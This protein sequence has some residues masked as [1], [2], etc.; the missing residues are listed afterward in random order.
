MPQ[1]KEFR[2]YLRTYNGVDWLYWFY[3]PITATVDNTTAVTE[4][5]R[6]P[7]GWQEYEIIFERGFTY[8]G[9]FTSFTTPL[10]FLKDGA[11]ILRHI[12]YTYGI[13]YKIELLVEQ[14]DHSDWTY[15]T[16]F[17][18]DIDMSKTQDEF[19]YLV[20]PIIEGGFVEKLKS[21]AETPYTYELWNNTDKKWIEHDGIEMEAK[22]SWS[23]GSTTGVEMPSNGFDE[24][25]LWG[26]YDTEGTNFDQVF[27]DVSLTPSVQR[28]VLRNNS[29]SSI[30]YLIKIRGTYVIS[31]NVSF[32]GNGYLTIR[33]I[34]YDTNG[35]F[36]AVHDLWITAS[37]IVG[38]GVST[39]NTYAV[40][41]SETVTIATGNQIA[42]THILSDSAGSA[43][44]AFTNGSWATTSV[45][46]DLDIIFNNRYETTYVPAL[47]AS[48]VF[49]LL[50][51]SISE[52]A[53]TVTSTLLTTTLNNEHY[54]SSGDGIRGLVNATFTTTFADFYKWVNSKFG[55][56][57]Y[58][59]RAAN[60]VYLEAK[61]V[62]FNKTMN[63]SYTITSVDDF[64][65]IPFTE[66]AFTNLSIGSRNF[67]YDAKGVDSNE[68]TNGRDEW[69]LTSKY[70]TT[71]TR[72]SGA[73]KEYVSPY[74][75]DVHGIEQVRANLSGK[76][77]ADASSDGEIFVLHCE[78]SSSGSYTPPFFPS[79]TEDLH[80]LFR[81]ALN[82]TAGASYWQINNIFSP[83]SAYNIFYSSARCL[84]R[85]GDYLRSIFKMVDTSLFYYKGSG[86]VNTNGSQMSTEEGAV[87]D[88]INE[89]D[90]VV[91]S[92]LCDNDAVLFQ[93]FIFEFNTRE[94]IDLYHT[95]NNN[96]FDYIRF[97][98]KGNTYDGYILKATS[99]PSLRGETGFRLLATHDT[100]ITNLIR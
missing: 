5:Q 9:L 34:E 71:F 15:S 45:T 30:D 61:S 79:L 54:L 14:L 47:K 31:T 13:E 96:P 38:A 1:P 35:T 39:G 19:D 2:H 44:T 22:L 60:T 37:P 81:T 77:L 24:F 91:V 93:P 55:C 92:G 97:T 72:L 3:E 25:P 11:A 16:L 58:Y 57:L 78:A 63:P 82:P 50:M 18:G 12:K 80:S 8:Y 6:A 17:R 20:V 90:D 26:Y 73:S 21:R 68:V 94:P 86:K 59:D 67:D 51:N 48:K 40:D 87:P 23:N 83:E 53:I 33:V 62:V 41:I 88:I 74:R 10:K 28:Q 7:E 29:S 32:G 85:N 42:I 99:K 84:F 64:K 65:C 89:D 43:G 75:D 76:E 4:L 56:A 52:D 100:D 95:I 27:Y 46:A 69:N 36:V 70:L 98:F 49:E 66:E